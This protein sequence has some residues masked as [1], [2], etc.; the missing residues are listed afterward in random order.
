MA[1]TERRSED[2][3]LI[4][5]PGTCRIG[6]GRRTPARV[7]ELSIH[8]CRLSAGGR[9]LTPQS[10]VMVKL[11]NRDFLEA[12]VA[13]TDRD[14]AGLNWTRALHPAILDHIFAFHARETPDAS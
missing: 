9:M 8:G 3:L 12:R 13:W 14:T 2:R 1:T 4:E 10:Y 6:S 5:M 11:D 7:T